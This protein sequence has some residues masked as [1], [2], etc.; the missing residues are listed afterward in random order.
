MGGFEEHVVGVRRELPVYLPIHTIPKDL[1][2][3]CPY[4]VVEEVVTESGEK[5]FIAKCRFLDRYL[6][7]NQAKKCVSYWSECPFYLYAMQKR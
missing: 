2:S 5:V 6:T 4:F 3:D 1:K 7:R